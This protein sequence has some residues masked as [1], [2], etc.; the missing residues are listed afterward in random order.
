[1]LQNQVLVYDYQRCTA[2]RHI[3]LQHPISVLCVL[4]SKGSIAF[5]D[6][7]G[8]VGILNVCSSRVTLLP[9]KPQLKYAHVFATFAVS[10]TSLS[11]KTICGI[12]F[13]KPILEQLVVM[14]LMCLLDALCRLPGPVPSHLFVW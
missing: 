4:P 5:A 12:C 11:G 9:G 1:M 14:Y 7:S 10:C 2:V 13:L 3:S 6:M 8:R